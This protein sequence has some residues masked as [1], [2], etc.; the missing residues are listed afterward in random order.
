MD[1]N[2]E[3]ANWKIKQWKHSY[4]LK[5]KSEVVFENLFNGNEVLG[6]YIIYFN[7]WNIMF[8]LFLNCSDWHL[9]S[10]CKE[11]PSAFKSHEPPST[12]VIL[13]THHRCHYLIIYSHI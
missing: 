1:V 10:A 2:F 3:S 13:K 8:T 6:K 11:A 4:E 5:D 9:N 12:S 7:N